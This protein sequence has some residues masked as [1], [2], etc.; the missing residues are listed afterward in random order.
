MN[1][2]WDYYFLIDNII[3]VTNYAR[4]GFV[5]NVIIINILFFNQTVERRRPS[6]QKVIKY[7]HPLSQ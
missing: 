4:S 1:V 7:V 5:R 3:T 2:D 6:T